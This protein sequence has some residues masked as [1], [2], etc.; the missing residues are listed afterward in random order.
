MGTDPGGTLLVHRVRSRESGR[1]T[2]HLRQGHDTEREEEAHTIMKKKKPVPK[3][4]ADEEEHEFWMTHDSS[5]YESKPID[6][7]EIEFD[8]PVKQVISFRIDPGEYEGIKRLARRKRV[9]ATSLLREW[10]DQRYKRE[11]KKLTH[12]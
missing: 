11:V 12:A 9:R 10:V 6:A 5:D 2:D 1:R 8:I 4:K 7:G 3:F